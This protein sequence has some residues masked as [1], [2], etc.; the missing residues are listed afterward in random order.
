MPSKHFHLLI[1]YLSLKGQCHEIFSFYVQGSA[2]AELQQRGVWAA[3][4]PPV[5]PQA[6]HAGVHES[7]NGALLFERRCRLL[8]TDYLGKRGHLVWSSKQYNNIFAIL[9]IMENIGLWACSLLSITKLSFGIYYKQ[10]K[11][12]PI[13]LSPLLILKI[14]SSQ[15]GVDRGTT[16]HSNV[17]TLHTIAYIL[18]HTKRVTIVC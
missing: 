1:P 6:L 10:Q 3:H 18:R 9:K 7:R 13:A 16:Y 8:H 11:L 17:V 4:L 5:P 15:R 14:L 12:N 2:E